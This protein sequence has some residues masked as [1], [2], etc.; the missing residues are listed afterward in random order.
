[1]YSPS[2]ANPFTKTQLDI[3][4]PFTNSLVP[5]KTTADNVYNF[6]WEGG[7]DKKLTKVWILDNGNEGEEKWGIE[8][9][10]YWL[11]GFVTLPSNSL[12]GL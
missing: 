11:K 5:N 4:R 3:S 9:H 8:L 7:R 2:C 12:L 1:M 10:S 6:L